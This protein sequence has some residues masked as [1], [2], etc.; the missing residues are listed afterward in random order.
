MCGF[1]DMLGRST[2]ASEVSSHLSQCHG[3]T[4]FRP[5]ADELSWSGPSANDGFCQSKVEEKVPCGQP[6]HPAFSKSSPRGIFGSE[7]REHYASGG[8]G[9]QERRLLSDPP[10]TRSS[11]TNPRLP[12]PF[13]SLLPGRC[14]QPSLA[15]TQQE[16]PT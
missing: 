2:T 4:P 5:E 16:S 14:P 13:L 10:H 11:I 12:E 6:R 1:D 15:K 8:E 3:T 7:S 9:V